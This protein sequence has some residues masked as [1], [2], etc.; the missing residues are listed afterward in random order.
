LYAQFQYSADLQN[1]SYEI[2]YVVEPYSDN[3]VFLNDGGTG[4]N[5]ITSSSITLPI[6]TGYTLF[7]LKVQIDTVVGY[8]NVMT[9]GTAPI[10]LDVTITGQPTT[11]TSGI[12]FTFNYAESPDA[13][14]RAYNYCICKCQ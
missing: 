1:N 4:V 2:S 10:V 14:D 8:G 6:F 13:V 9:Y 11:I 3:S 12:Y 5:T 7:K